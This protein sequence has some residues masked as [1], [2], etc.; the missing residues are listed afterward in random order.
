MLAMHS[1]AHRFELNFVKF[2]R[3]RYSMCGVRAR[4]REI[5]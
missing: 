4:Y 5:I 1:E 2:Y 3:F